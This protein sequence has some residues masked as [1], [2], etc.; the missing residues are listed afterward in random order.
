MTEIEHRRRDALQPINSLSLSLK[1]SRLVLKTAAA[2][3]SPF[4][5]SR[6]FTLCLHKREFDDDETQ[7]SAH[8]PYQTSLSV[9]C[10]QTIA[11]CTPRLLHEV[12]HPHRPA[13]SLQQFFLPAVATVHRCIALQILSRDPLHG[14][15]VVSAGHSASMYLRRIPSTGLVQSASRPLRALQR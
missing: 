2:A 14:T 6:V 13:H 15:R 7:G 5:S 11:S 4:E 12:E 3:G 9:V 10:V 1:C 8:R